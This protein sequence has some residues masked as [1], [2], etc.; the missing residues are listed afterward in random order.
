MACSAE[1]RRARRLRVAPDLLAQT[2]GALLADPSTLATMAS[3]S[4]ALARP[5]AA[6]DVAGELLAAAGAA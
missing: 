3:A 2:V 1:A 6:R 5:H 4:A